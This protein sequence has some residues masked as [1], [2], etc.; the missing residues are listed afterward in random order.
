MTTQ[1]LLS[2]PPRS[3]SWHRLA[4]LSIR[5]EQHPRLVGRAEQTLHEG[6]C[7]HLARAGLPVEGG[8]AVL[9]QFRDPLLTLRRRKSM[10]R[11]IQS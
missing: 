6:I 5:G 10:Q 3:L 8:H 1:T 4:L 11:D 2:L 7:S 9:N